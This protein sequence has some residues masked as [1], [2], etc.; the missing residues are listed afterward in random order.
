MIKNSALIFQE[1]KDPNEFYHIAFDSI[2]PKIKSQL[3]Q[4]NPLI[5]FT[6][7]D[8]IDN[9]IQE[10][11]GFLNEDRV[12]FSRLNDL[13]DPSFGEPDELFSFLEN[14]VQKFFKN[15]EKDLISLEEMIKNKEDHLLIS[16]EFHRLKSTFATFG[17]EATRAFIE[18]LQKKTEFYTINDLNQ[19]KNY[20]FGNKSLLKNYLNNYKTK[21]AA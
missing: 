11:F 9:V 8:N 18:G 12:E 15:F 17:L 2:N 16:K 7:K 6:T 4:I 19:L 1:N 13:L 21:G 20:Y 14:L 10:N 5:I 3:K